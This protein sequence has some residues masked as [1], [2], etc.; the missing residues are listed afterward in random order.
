MPLQTL[1]ILKKVVTG[2]SALRGVS[3]VGLSGGKENLPKAGVGDID[4]F[5]YC[6]KIP[7][8]ETRK[9]LFKKLEPFITDS[10]VQIINSPFWGSGDFLKIN[11]VE[12]WL[13]F[14]TEKE[15]LE[16]LQAVLRGEHLDKTN[17]YFYP[18]GRC[19]MFN[20]MW[21]LH[22]SKGF[23]KDI[24]Q[25][26][27]E[28]PNSLVQQMLKHHLGELDVTEDFQRALLRSDVLFYHFVLDLA[29]DHFLLALFA[30]N[31]QYFPSRKRS[32]E[33]IAKFSK[34][35]VNC[36]ERLLEVIQLGASSTTLAKSYQV[37]C[38]LVRELQ[39]LCNYM[40]LIEEFVP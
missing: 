26:L 31:K 27:I 7:S 1:D 16:Y 13:M 40:L 32:L 5:V 3:S 6:S 2:L 18:I 30:L 9:K 22:D 33:H 35:P 17:N 28:Y 10:N 12:T 20:Q 19:A 29:I 4:I 21:I 34:K 23:L 25:L 39:G 24:Q 36:E 38:E 8:V 37:W 11:E 14:F 15:T